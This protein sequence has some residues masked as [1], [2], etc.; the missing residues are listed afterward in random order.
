MLNSPQL[1]QSV[2][3]E[4]IEHKVTLSHA[5]KAGMTVSDVELQKMIA[6][7]EAFHDQSGNSRASAIASCFRPGAVAGAFENQVR[8]NIMLEQV[9]SVY[10]GSAFVPE[11]VAERLLK[12]REQEREVSQVLF[13]PSDYRK[14]AEVSDAD[15]G[16]VLHGHK[17]EFLVPERV[18]VEFVVLSLEAYQRSMQSATKKSGS[19]MRTT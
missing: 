15:A 3:N 7:V 12:I 2:L 9:R 8:S 16:K 14:Q 19:S 10:S 17:G 1:R 18:K 5:S 6:A 4:L 11:S 13:N